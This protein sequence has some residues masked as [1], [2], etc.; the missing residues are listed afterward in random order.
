M[1]IRIDKLMGANQAAKVR[2]F[3]IQL[4][5]LRTT[6]NKR[7]TSTKTLWIK[8]KRFNV[9]AIDI[10]ASTFCSRCAK[11]NQTSLYQ[12]PTFLLFLRNSIYHIGN[13][14]PH[15]VIAVCNLAPIFLHHGHKNRSWENSR[16]AHINC[17][18]FYPPNVLF[19]R[20]R[21]FI[22]FLILQQF[23]IGR[24]QLLK[25]KKHAM[26]F[27]VTAFMINSP[28]YVRRRIH[29]VVENDGLCR[30]NAFMPCLI[31]C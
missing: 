14:F 27:I 6:D 12:R 15:V 7:F 2:V 16:I 18:P 13:L 17:L 30:N 19:C 25:F 3:F 20:F 11:H 21:C 4:C 1:T 22:C 28:F 9:A 29:V 24:M 8:G 26:P 10:I 31:V 5:K 23:Q